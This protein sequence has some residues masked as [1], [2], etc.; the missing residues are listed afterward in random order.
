V[1]LVEFQPLKLSEEEAI[2][3]AIDESELLELFWWEG[4]QMLLS[5]SVI[6]QGRLVTLPATPHQGRAPVPA[7]TYTIVTL[8]VP[9]RLGPHGV[10]LN[11]DA[12]GTSVRLDATAKLGTRGVG[13]TAAAPGASSS[14]HTGSNADRDPVVVPLDPPVVLDVTQDKDD[15]E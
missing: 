15:K 8:G 5:E 6:S 9:A 1:L 7:S 14:D 12:R 11:V 3:K 10:G 2:Q 4:L 13:V